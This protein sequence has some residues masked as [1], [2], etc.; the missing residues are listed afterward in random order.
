MVADVR[1]VE[2]VAGSQAVLYPGMTQSAMESTG[3]ASLLAEA[4]DDAV[5]LSCAQ[6]GCHHKHGQ[7]MCEFHPKRRKDDRKSRTDVT[8]G[9]RNRRP[10]R[11]KTMCPGERMCKWRINY[12]F[13]K[14]NAAYSL[15]PKCLA[16][17]GHDMGA[18]CVSRLLSTSDVTV[19]MWE[20]L[21][22]WVA[23]PLCGHKLRKVSEYP[24]N[25]SRSHS[26]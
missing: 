19:K 17:Q 2:V 20:D 26:Q 7:F 15:R 9:R 13:S 6:F 18:P 24:A 23:I 11:W 21:C 1:T 14:K 25:S 5:Q 8:T 3:V 12:T 22:R 4:T 16:H 10:P